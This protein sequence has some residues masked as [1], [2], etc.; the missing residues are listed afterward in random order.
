[1]TDTPIHENRYT[2]VAMDYNPY[3]RFGYDEVEL[4]IVK[5]TIHFSQ[6]GRTS[7]EP[8]DYFVCRRQ[9]NDDV[10]YECHRQDGFDPEK[11]ICCAYERPED[12]QIWQTFISDNPPI[13][14]FDEDADR[15][16]IDN[17]Y[18]DSY[19]DEDGDI[20]Y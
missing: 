10:W 14:V 18:S 2:D 7:Y 19:E 4:K 1:M 15:A 5:Y 20:P 11:P 3:D 16:V 17:P 12:A 9:V 8:S 6:D 13:T